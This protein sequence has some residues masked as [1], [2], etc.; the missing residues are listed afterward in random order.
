M[1]KVPHSGTAGGALSGLA[2]AS[3]SSSSGPMTMRWAHGREVGI[4]QRLGT[5]FVNEQHFGLR[6]VADSGDLRR[7]QA[8]VDGRQRHTRLGGTEDQ[9]HVLDG[10]LRHDGPV[11]ARRARPRPAA[12]AAV[13]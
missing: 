4:A 10:V 5:Q 9:L 3:Q 8:R 6:V 13:T 12:S 2:L 7:R 1:V 11:G